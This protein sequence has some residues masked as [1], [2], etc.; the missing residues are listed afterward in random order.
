MQS[1]NLRIARTFSEQDREDFVRDPFDYIARFFENSLTELHART[2]EIEGRFRRIDANRFS[3][4]AYRHGQP[5]SRC[6]IAYG[7]RGFGGADVTYL[8]NDSGAA[9]S[10]NEALTARTDEQSLYLEANLSKAWF[11]MVPTYRDTRRCIGMRDHS[12]SSDLA[13]MR[14]CWCPCLG[15]VT[16]F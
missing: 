7:G 6:T 10:F 13:E 5:I 11:H 4:V 1:S 2:P 14:G 16:H 12:D 3:C 9:N 8:A 15:S